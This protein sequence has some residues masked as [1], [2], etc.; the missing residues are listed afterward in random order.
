MLVSRGTVALTLTISCG[1][2]VVVHDRCFDRNNFIVKITGFDGGFC[3]FEIAG[4]N[5][6]YLRESVGTFQRAACAFELASELVLLEIA[7]IAT[8]MRLSRPTASL[9]T[10]SRVMFSTPQAITTSA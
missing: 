1:V 7:A 8:F 6:R 2:E 4:Q 3:A 10:G 5:R 9:P